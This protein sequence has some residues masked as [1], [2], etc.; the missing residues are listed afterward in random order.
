MKT[1]IMNHLRVAALF[2]LSLM[3]SGITGTLLPARCQAAVAEPPA[4]PGKGLRV[5]Q[6]GN[7]HLGALRAHHDAGAPGRPCAL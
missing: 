6:V 2:A 4:S 3:V 1:S 7:S 5:F